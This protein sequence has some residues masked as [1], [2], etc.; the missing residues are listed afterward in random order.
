[1]TKTTKGL[2]A[3]LSILVG[4]LL[5]SYS[6]RIDRRFNPTA[7][8]STQTRTSAPTMAPTIFL[9][10]TPTRRG[11]QTTTLTRTGSRTATRI[12]SPTAS[13]TLPPTVTLPAPG[14][15]TP[16]ELSSATQ[17]PPFM[18]GVTPTVR[19]QGVFYLYVS[20]FTHD[21]SYSCFDLDGGKRLDIGNNHV[22]LCLLSG[23]RSDSA[24]YL[25][26]MYG[27]KR[28]LLNNAQPTFQSCGVNLPNFDDSSIP[29]FPD[30]PYTCI[31]TN[32]N[33]LAIIIY[34]SMQTTSKPDGTV[35]WEYFTWNEI[36]Q[37]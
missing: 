15:S 6:N 5:I 34:I 19:N 12:S 16:T 17:T 32:D 11:I 3:V 9:S 23:P 13:P 18:P 4:S 26:M 7:P 30:H 20:Y 10:T 22:D 31:L 29:D 35:K 28:F 1:M 21:M 25:E 33:R 36:I 8:S 27:A 37:P 14:S 2:L 24:W